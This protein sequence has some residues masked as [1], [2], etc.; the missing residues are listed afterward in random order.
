MNGNELEDH[1]R[2]MANEIDNYMDNV[3]PIEAS[4]IVETFV[5]D[6]FLQEGFVNNGL[7][8]WQDVKRRDPQSPWYGFQPLNKAQF[9]QVRATDP[10]LK[11]TG[12]LFDATKV[13]TGRG[14]VIVSNDKPYAAIHNEGGT[15]YVFGK[16]PFQM[17]Q[18]QFI[19][20]SKELDESIIE[21]IENGINDIVNK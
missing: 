2:N 15:A 18:R 9:S 7:Q 5:Q 16:T 20:H 1:L 4:V 19:G 6:N 17:P 8:P 14:E 21:N 13:T 11:D 12:E 10:I 3:F